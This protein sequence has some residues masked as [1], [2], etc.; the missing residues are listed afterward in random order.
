MTYSSLPA[1]P[2]TTASFAFI[3]D[4]ARNLAFWFLFPLEERT[5]VNCFLNHNLPQCV[6]P[7]KNPRISPTERNRNPS[8]KTRP[9]SRSV[10]PFL[11][12]HL[13]SARTFR[14][15]LVALSHGAAFSIRVT[16]RPLLAILL[17]LLEVRPDGRMSIFVRPTPSLR[18]VT[19]II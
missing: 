9:P 5:T 12:L 7:A 11:P 16:P 4:A 19:R 13:Y 14:G 8:K 1:P 2:S 3:D 18:F 6:V 15:P 10:A 17:H